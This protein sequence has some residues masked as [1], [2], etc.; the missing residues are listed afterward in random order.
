MKKGR[1]QLTSEWSSSS[2]KIISPRTVRRRLFNA[3]YK[4]HTT[5]RKSYR[6]PH[7]YYTWFIVAR[8]HYK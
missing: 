8:H 6:K 7:H 2:R 4:S 3:G 1:R 5:K